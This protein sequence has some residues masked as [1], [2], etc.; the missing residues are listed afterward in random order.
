MSDAWTAE[1]SLAFL[2]EAIP[3]AFPIPILSAPCQGHPAAGGRGE[4]LC[5][6]QPKQPLTA[7]SRLR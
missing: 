3:L 1:R 4:R 7:I 2:C 5:S 6:S